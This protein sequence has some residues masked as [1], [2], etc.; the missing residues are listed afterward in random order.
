MKTT[1]YCVKCIMGI[2]KSTIWAQVPVDS[3]QTTLFC[4]NTVVVF[5]EHY[6]LSDIYCGCLYRYRNAELMTKRGSDCYGYS[7]IC[8]VVVFLN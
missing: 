2:K 1:M 5:R 7:A 6:E 8:P 4:C 3:I